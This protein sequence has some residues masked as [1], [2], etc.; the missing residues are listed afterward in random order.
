MRDSRTLRLRR[1]PVVATIILASSLL[2]GLAAAD[3]PAFKIVGYLSGRNVQKIDRLELD[4]LTHLNLAFANPNRE[5]QLEFSGRIDIRPTVASAHRAGLKVYISLAG[6]GRPD[7]ELWTSVLRPTSRARFIENILAYVQSNDLDGVDVDIE[8]NLLPALGELYAPFV[9]ELKDA[10][11]AQGKGISAALGATGV[12]PA[13]T[14]A[15]IEAYDF[16]NVMVYD[17]TGPWRP[18][19]VGPHSPY[20]FA[21]DAVRYWT[22]KRGIRS[23]RIVLGVPFYGYDFTKPVR[24]FAYRELVATDPAYAYQDTVGTKYYDGIPTIVK[25]TQLAK[26]QK[27]GGVMIW[28]LS[29]DTS[30][31][32]SLLRAMHQTAAAGDCE[33]RTF[34]KDEDGDGVGDLRKPF[35]ACQ[36]PAGYVEKR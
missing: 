23:E 20:S 9:I 18:D 31:E 28:E 4:K 30:D 32:L 13:V 5:G 3:E 29:Y 10:L 17:K 26:Q 25:K 35:Q 19:D 33:V 21:E 15:A 24:S 7:Q 34:F 11:H 1:G 12:H 2:H 27:L 14:Q 6:G 36:P 8:W 16:I 22:Q